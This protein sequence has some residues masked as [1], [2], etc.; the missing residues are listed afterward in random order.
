MLTTQ[1]QSAFELPKGSEALGRS[2]VELGA[3]LQRG[4][5]PIIQDRCSPPV[6]VEL[7]E[8]PKIAAESERV[9]KALL[10]YAEKLRQIE[11]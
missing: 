11:S 2:L 8:I 7:A 3:R 6:V 1:K 9:G 10:D 5:P 4:R